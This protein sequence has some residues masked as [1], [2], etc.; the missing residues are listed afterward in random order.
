MP[1]FRNEGLFKQ[2][3]EIILTA[4]EAH[5]DNKLKISLDIAYGRPGSATHCMF[6]VVFHVMDN[7]AV[8]L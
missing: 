1:F 7:K 2:I 8:I 3:L 5:K 4:K 6:Y